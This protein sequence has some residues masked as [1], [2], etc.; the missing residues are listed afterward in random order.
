MKSRVSLSRRDA[1]ALERGPEVDAGAY[2][3]AL[4]RLRSAL[5]PSPKRTAAKKERRAT[6]A[7]RRAAHN[8]ET[9]DIHREVAIRADGKCEACGSYFAPFSPA[10]MDHQA[11]RAKL[12]QSV[13]NCWLLCFACD[14][15]KTENRP[16]RAHW[17][18]KFAEHC[19]RHNYWSEAKRARRDLATA[20][21]KEAM[22]DAL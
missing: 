4:N 7:E 6:K 17:L 21:A 15:D 3:R 11:G 13:T 14:R 16:S 19:D 22:R 1:E 2:A 9:A 18:Q 5:K 12:P 8:A 10:H 20:Q